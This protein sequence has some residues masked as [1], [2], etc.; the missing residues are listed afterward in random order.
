[1]EVETVTADGAAEAAR[2]LADLAGSTPGRSLV[3]S[4]RP[5]VRDRAAAAGAV[6]ADLNWLLG[7][8]TGP[9]GSSNRL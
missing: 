3:V 7:L 5:E 2:V 6:A 4:G 9:T 8:D 1:V